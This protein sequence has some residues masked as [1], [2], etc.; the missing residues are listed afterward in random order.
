MEQTEPEKQMTQFTFLNLITR[1]IAGLGGGIL[2]T[3]VLLVIYILTVSIVAP[4][5]AP[6]GDESATLSPLFIFILMGMIFASTLA[7]NLIGPLLI[8]FTARDKYQR[9]TT[10]LFQLFIVN[11]VI[12][13]VL[14][15]IYL[16]S[17]S[18][19]MEFISYAA[20]L[21]IV[22]SVL[23]SALI[24]EII[25]NYR[26]ALLGVYS[27]IFAVL[28]AIAINI[29]LYQVTGNATILLF[30]ALPL[31]WGGIGFMFG[32]V[33][34]IYQWIVNTWGT[35]YLATFQ[36]YS[37]DYGVTEAEQIAEEERKMAEEPPAVDTEGVDFLRGGSGNG[38][39]E[40]TPEA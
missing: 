35:D 27:T 23:A 13:V 38:D 29:M 3:A 5:L 20:G 11:I 34:L 30:V 39:D 36:E 2:G 32:L 1:T 12:F 6:T 9:I 17:V 8:S 14:I 40:Q 33:G 18:I 24:F 28:S 16:F 10:S 15:P 21:Q 37:K 31:L 19:G 7:A 25:A 26:Y 22:F 4:V